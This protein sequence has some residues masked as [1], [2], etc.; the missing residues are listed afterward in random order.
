MATHLHSEDYQLSALHAKTQHQLAYLPSLPC[1][2]GMSHRCRLPI[3]EHPLS[4]R[5][6]IPVPLILFVV[7][8]PGYIL[9]Q[10]QQD[11]PI[12]A[13]MHGWV[14]LV[15]C[16]YVV[17]L[18]VASVGCCCVL[19]RCVC[20]TYCEMFVVYCVV[21]H[22]SNEFDILQLNYLEFVGA[23]ELTDLKVEG[24]GTPTC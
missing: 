19:C 15:V 18:N 2:P 13:S 11:W 22:M 23:R 5:L 9:Y 20:C 3:I 21:L 1:L 24:N 8:C 10:Q 4:L 12:S 17:S 16:C 7:R 6:M 14:D